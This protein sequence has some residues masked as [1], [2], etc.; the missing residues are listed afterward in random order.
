MGPDCLNSCTHN[1]RFVTKLPEV[2][3]LP[4]NNPG[5]NRTGINLTIVKVYCMYVCMYKNVIIKPNC[6]NKGVKEKPS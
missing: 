3:V 2:A 6:I 4:T 5:E 1:A